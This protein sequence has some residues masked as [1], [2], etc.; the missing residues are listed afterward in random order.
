[1]DAHVDWLLTLEVHSTSL[2]IRAHASCHI[3]RSKSCASSL[4]LSLRITTTST[5]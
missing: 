4:S 3:E 1:M 5:R 2:N